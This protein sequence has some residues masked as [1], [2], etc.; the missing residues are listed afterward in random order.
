MQTNEKPYLSE[1]NNRRY[2]SAARD[3]LFAVLDARGIAL[4]AEQRALIEACQDPV[5]VR[6]WVARAAT[7]SA[8]DEVLSPASLARSGASPAA[9]R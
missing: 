2:A 9:P 8:A 5:A 3:M 7:A 1:S 4:T 6:A